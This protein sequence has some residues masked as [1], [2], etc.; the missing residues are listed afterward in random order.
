MNRLLACMIIVAGVLISGCASSPPVRYY[1]LEPLPGTQPDVQKPY[2][3]G[4]GPIQFPEYL[5]R[6]QIVSRTTGAELELAEFDRWSEPLAGAFQ[7]V[8][9]LNLDQLLT[10][11]AVVEFPY[12]NLWDPAYRL[13]G[14]VSQF[15]TDESGR[16]VLN[17]QWGVVNI[18]T[19]DMLVRLRRD[20]YTAQAADPGDYDGVVQALNQ[21]VEEFSR[22][23]AQAISDEMGP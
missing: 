11:W 6:P 3:L 9:T 5:R 8:L 18:E 16:A 23:V 4:L 21:T 20:M 10:E 19:T 1:S 14:R 2:S 17:V 15:E 13:Q 12:G 7:R 22:T